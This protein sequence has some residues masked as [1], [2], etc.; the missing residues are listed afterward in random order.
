M[1]VRKQTMSP[2]AKRQKW[3]SLVSDVVAEWLDLPPEPRAISAVRGKLRVPFN[4]PLCAFESA[5]E[6]D[7]L[8]LCRTELRVQAVHSKQLV[9][10]FTDTATG[11]RRRYTPD[12]VVEVVTGEGS[13]PERFVVEVKASQDLWRTRRERRQAYAAAAVWSLSQPST[14]FVIASDKLLGS[15][16]VTNARLLSSH[17]EMPRD[18][19]IE[20]LIL[21]IVRSSAEIKLS[22]LVDEVARWGYHRH[23]ILPVI[24]FLLARGGLWF[25]RAIP[26][27]PSTWVSFGSPWRV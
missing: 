21:S 4:G 15:A 27:T 20:E 2:F 22:E 26:I 17:M 18:L 11:S 7:F 13:A 23:F 16:W 14:T 24:Y 8:T 3:A 9:I 25:D 12:F 6:R 1:S 5:L 10:H 19:V